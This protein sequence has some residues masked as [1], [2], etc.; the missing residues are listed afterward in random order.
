M[1]SGSKK[2]LS[3]WTPKN[4]PSTLSKVESWRIFSKGISAGKVLLKGI[5]IRQDR[6]CWANCVASL[7]ALTK[8]IMYDNIH[9]QGIHT[10]REVCA[11]ADF[12]LAAIPSPYKPP[13]ALENA[14]PSLFLRNIQVFENHPLAHLPIPDGVNTTVI[15]LFRL[16]K[17]L[18]TN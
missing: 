2:A 7:G 10:E 11:F 15:C 4:I 8:K 13:L 12:H 1:Q 3:I 16:S 18:M 14:F 6:T 17:A 5:S 9:A